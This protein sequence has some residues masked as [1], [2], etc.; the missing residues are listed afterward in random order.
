MPDGVKAIRSRG[1]TTV[2]VHQTDAQPFNVNWIAADS[3]A[4]YGPGA[5]YRKVRI[6]LPYLVTF[7]AFS[8]LRRRLT[9][10]PY[11]ECFF[12][13]V[14]VSSLSEGELCYPALLNCSR[15]KKPEG[16]P[17]AWICTQFLD[18]QRLAAIED[19]N[20]RFRE[21]FRAVMQTLLGASFNQSSEHHEDG[22]WY[23]ASVKQKIDPRIA[24]IERWETE[25][26]KDPMFALEVPWIGTGMNIEQ[27]LERI[28]SL[29]KADDAGVTSSAD[30]ARLIFN[31]K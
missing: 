17:L 13:N 8:M 15:F 28:F 4:P 16:K 12:S 7:C 1:A 2:L 18:Y 30:V 20:K 22:S 19:Q 3:P 31:Q 5:T 29:R 26:A 23:T 14:P 21:S 25:T 9:L 6:A 27:M 10:T 11:N 24:T